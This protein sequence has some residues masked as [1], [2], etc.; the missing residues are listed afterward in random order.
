MTIKI[1]IVLND[2]YP[3]KAFKN[4]KDAW[5]FAEQEDPGGEVLVLKDVEFVE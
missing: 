5:E 3:L 1:W 4:Y 2:D